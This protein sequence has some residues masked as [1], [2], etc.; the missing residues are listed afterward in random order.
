MKS[1][2]AALFLALIAQAGDSRWVE[3]LAFWA[4]ADVQRIEQRVTEIDAALKSLPEPA[5][6]NSSSSIGFKTALDQDDSEIWVEVTLPKT[7][8]VDRVVL[9]PALGKG[10]SGVL[11]G[12]GFPT[13]FK[14]EAFDD[15]GA[16]T[17]VFD[18]KGLDVKTEGCFPVTARFASQPVKRVRLTATQPWTRDGAPVL[19]LSEMFILSSERNV[20]LGATVTSSTSNELPLSWARRNLVDMV[21]PL[22]LPTSPRSSSSFGYHSAIANQADA[23]KSVTITLPATVPL[24]EVCLVPVRMTEVPLW[25]DYGFP[26]RFKIE[27]ATAPDFSDAHLIYQS[28][29]NKRPQSPGSNVLHLPANQ[30]PARY[31]RITATELW[32]RREDFIF[33][34]AEVQAISAGKNIAFGASVVASDSLEGDET[35][36]PAALTDGLAESGSII[37]LPQWFEQLEQRRVLEKERSQLV[38][39]RLKRIEQAQHTLVNGSVITAVSITLISGVL[40]WRQQRTRRRDAQRLHDKL[41]RD[42][43][44]EIGSNLGSIR[45]ICSFASQPDSTL[46]AMRDDLLDIER[47]AAESADSMRDMV[48]LI[49]P[50]RSTHSQDWL[51]VLHGLTERLLRGHVLDCALPSAPLTREP[52]IETRRELYLFCKEVLH[53]IGRHAKATHVRFQLRPTAAGLRV[54]ISDDGIGFD[55]QAGSAGH[56]LSNMQERAHAMKATLHMKTQPGQGTTI[57]LDVPQTARW[58]SRKS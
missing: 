37:S 22:G 36:Q 17:N 18:A 8:P 55:D 27:S 11:A 44:D 33:A 15:S 23:Q 3:R 46:E 43:H 29:P 2:T 7:M 48:Q 4:R 1:A 42:L 21:T 35:W 56:G 49:S 12:Y 53:N 45:L 6:I 40:L 26:V 52:D 34:L 19:A 58:Q 14:I 51:T 10:A 13:R 50:R 39:E 57:Q 54:E 5:L 25:F 28:T 47:V 31:L 30:T 38:T 20:A 16:A 24:D 41:A 32:K 9:V